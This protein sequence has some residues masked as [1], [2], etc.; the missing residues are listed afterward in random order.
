MLVKKGFALVNFKDETNNLKVLEK[1]AI[2]HLPFSITPYKDGDLENQ[3]Q[4]V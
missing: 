3:E 4:K 2:Q 1:A